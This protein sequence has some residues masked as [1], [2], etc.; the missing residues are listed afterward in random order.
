MHNSPHP[1]NARVWKIRLYLRRSVA[2]HLEFLKSVEAVC[3]DH[4][5]DN[6]ALEVVN[7]ETQLNEIECAAMAALPMVVRLSPRPI[8]RVAG[9]AAVEKIE[10]ELGFKGE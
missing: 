6:A 3:R 5:L 10:Q 1:N 7:V 4:G 2:R 9:I 8:C